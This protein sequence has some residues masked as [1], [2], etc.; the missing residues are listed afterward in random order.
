M[1]WSMR[2]WL[3]AEKKE[4]TCTCMPSSWNII[5]GMGDQSH[6]LERAILDLRRKKGKDMH[7]LAHLV[8]CSLRHGS[9]DDLS[10]G[11]CWCNGASRL[12]MNRDSTRKPGGVATAPSAKE[13]AARRRIG[14]PV[15]GNQWVSGKFETICSDKR[16]GAGNVPVMQRNVRPH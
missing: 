3:F 4:K 2:F 15:L 16:Y 6:G 12:R 1:D 5:F 13:Q 10:P 9:R 7:L 14:A 11:F 8:E